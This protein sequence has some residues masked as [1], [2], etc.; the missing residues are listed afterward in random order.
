MDLILLKDVDNLGDANDIV[1]VKPG[2]GRNFLIPQG[3]AITATD[4]N[5]KVHAHLGRIKDSKD[6]LMT[7]EFR[8]IANQLEAHTLI[9][10]TKAGTSGK[11]FGS[12]TNVQIARA[13]KDTLDMDIERRKITLPEEIKE[14]G[15]YT[16]AILLS[17]EVTANVKIEVKA[18]AAAQ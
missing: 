6:A 12:V 14:L 9:V 15:E 5:K 18:T 17:K 2:Y 1:S 7:A 13:I 10:E 8:T 16:V 3:F 4:N 11:I